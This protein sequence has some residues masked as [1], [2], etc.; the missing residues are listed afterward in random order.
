MRSLIGVSVLYVLPK[1]KKHLTALMRH[2]A[3]AT[4]S[5]KAPF[6]DAEVSQGDP[7][8]REVINKWV[9]PF[10]MKRPSKEGYAEELKRILPEL[11][12]GIIDSL[13]AEYNWR[14]RGVGAILASVTGYTAA[15]D[16]IGNHL[17]KSELCYAG[18][19]YAIS[20]ATMGGEQSIEYFCNYLDHYLARKDLYFDQAEVYS[21]LK[22]LDI[23]KAKEYEERWQGFVAGK[24]GWDINRSFKNVTEDIEAVKQI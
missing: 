5:H 24:E 15:R 19:S 7:L 3:G 22:Y 17:L 21:A 18:K 14:P 23:D 6:A 20:L 1:M 13:L 11:T 8:T 4:I 10:Y 12:T 9:H 16:T 2:I